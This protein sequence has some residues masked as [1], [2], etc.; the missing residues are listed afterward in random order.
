MQINVKILLFKNF[1]VSE[2]YFISARTKLIKSDSKDC[3]KILK[4]KNKYVL[5]AKYNISS[6]S[7][8]LYK[9]FI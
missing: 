2:V 5:K 1:G 9:I 4:Y 7:F 6:K 3:Y 8:K